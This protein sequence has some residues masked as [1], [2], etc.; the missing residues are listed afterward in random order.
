MTRQI[1]IS[2]DDSWFVAED[3]ET[4]VASQGK[5]LEDAMAN[6]KEALEL[7]FEDKPDIVTP[8]HSYMLSTLEVFA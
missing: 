5:T 4:N 1:L 2:K 7:Y 3:I 6:L 8:I